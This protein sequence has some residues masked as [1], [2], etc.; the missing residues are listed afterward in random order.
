MVGPA[1]GGETGTTVSGRRSIAVCRV[2]VREGVKG[3]GLSLAAA[4]GASEGFE[5]PICPFFLLCC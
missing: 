3:L 2:A 1:A 4:F 5:T